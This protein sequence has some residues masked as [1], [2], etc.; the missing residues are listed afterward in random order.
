MQHTGSSLNSIEVVDLTKSYGGRYVLKGLNLAVPAAKNLVIFGRSG[1]GKSVLLR[2]IIGLESPDS[3]SIFINS[4][5]LADL[6]RS[7]ETKMGMLFQNSALFDSLTIA[8]NVGFY[9]EHHPD[10]VTKSKYAASEVKERVAEALNKVGLSGSE[11]KMPSELSGGQKRRAALAR[12]LIYSPK[13]ILYDEPTTGLD[14][15][16]AEQI[17][18]LIKEVQTDLEATSILV[19]HDIKSGLTIG[20]LFAIQTE[21]HLD[22][23]YSRD[24]FLSSQ[25]DLVQQFLKTSK[26]LYERPI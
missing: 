26:H 20:D 15:I 16:T 7:H 23:I 18:D 17:N 2:H 3:G 4:I 14:P 21:G 5:P 19:T 13:I 1:C 10:G 9:L 6:N 25:N 12:L 11:N 8:E 22:K 24:E